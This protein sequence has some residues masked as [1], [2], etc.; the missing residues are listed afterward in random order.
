MKICE[1][2]ELVDS[3]SSRKRTLSGS[4]AGQ[5]PS[6]LP[7]LPVEMKQEIDVV[8]ETPLMIGKCLIV[9]YVLKLS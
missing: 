3:R 8:H 6:F 4:S 9:N 7:L 5:S 1:E 2:V